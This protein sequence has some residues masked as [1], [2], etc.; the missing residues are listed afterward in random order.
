M[1][2]KK[3]Q[4]S[5]VVVGNV[6]ATKGQVGMGRI[7]GILNTKRSQTA[8]RSVGSQSRPINWQKFTK[9]SIVALL[10]SI[11]I[12]LYCHMTSARSYPINN[13]TVSG[14]YQYTNPEILKAHL[15]PFVDK[16]FFALNVAAIKHEV[17]QLPW[18][19]HAN[20]RRH[21][22]DK[23]SIT[24]QE[25]EP[26]ALW[27]HNTVIVESGQV[28]TPAKGTLPVGIPELSGPADQEKEV[29]QRYQEMLAL[30][31][32][33]KLQI[34]SLVL[35]PRL[36]WQLKLSDGTQLQ[37]GRED[38]IGRLVHFISAYK[39]IYAGHAQQNAIVDMRYDNGMAV[40]WLKK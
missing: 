21:W 5:L 3:L 40:S 33:L 39:K 14:D 35:S 1:W 20:V 18:V 17:E 29:M 19:A 6:I 37:L 27:N 12:W 22:P 11:C 28:I 9:I 16:S 7:L 25:H 30:L 34:D 31:K 38:V 15:L 2:E 8:Q 23:V 26:V 10:T 32:P 13:V 4:S 24:L 36:A